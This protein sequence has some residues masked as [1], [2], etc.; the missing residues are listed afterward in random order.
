MCLTLL[1]AGMMCLVDIYK[2]KKEKIAEDC[3]KMLAERISLWQLIVTVRK[4]FSLLYLF[5][6]VF[7]LL[8]VTNSAAVC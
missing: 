8:D 3:G 2:N 7:E 1:S 6:V 5:V 4:L